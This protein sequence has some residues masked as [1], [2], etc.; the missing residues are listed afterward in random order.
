MEIN[1][2]EICK[3]SPG[4]LKSLIREELLIYRNDQQFPFLILHRS[5][6]NYRK[7]LICRKNPA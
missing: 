3:K 2:E 6:S 4:Q 1:S 5:S 7:L